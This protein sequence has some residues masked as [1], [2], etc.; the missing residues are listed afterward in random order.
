MET[1]VINLVKKQSTYKLIIPAEVERKIRYLCQK[2]PNV[3]WSGTLFYTHEGSMEDDTLVITC[4]DIFVMD[5]GSAAYTEF[6]MSPDVISYMC[7]KPELL[8][9]QMGLIHSHNKMATFFSGTDTNTLKEE[10]RDRNH[11]VSLIVN[12]EGTYTAAI[13]R[14]TKSTRT[15]Q[16]S[17]SYGSFNDEVVAD[18][19]EYSEEVEQIEYFYMNIVNEGSN[20]SFEELDTRLSEIRKNKASKTV[21]ISSNYATPGCPSN[22]L[23]STKPSLFETTYEDIKPIRSTAFDNNHV[24]SDKDVQQG[25]LQLITGSIIIRYDSKID[26]AKWANTMPKLFGDRFGVDDEGFNAFKSWAEQHCEFILFDKEPYIEN[27]EEEADWVSNYA[28]AIC[29]ELDCLPNNKY[30]ET[31]KSIVS[32]WIM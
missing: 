11:F 6:D 29:N 18:S 20:Y 30:V 4:K 32:Q 2:I 21:V 25:F 26:V 7:D 28:L 1:T 14:R 19:K 23:K 9:V 12:N 5:I 17:Y 31:F 13:T 16:E 15:I 27:P 3:E 8:D 24:I 10:G 22:T